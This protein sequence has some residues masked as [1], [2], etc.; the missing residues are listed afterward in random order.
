MDE[1]SEYNECVLLTNYLDDLKMEKKI[2][3]FTHVPNETFTKYWNV[4]VKNKMQ[5]V[6]PGFPDYII[7]FPNQMIIIEMK[8]RK[9][10]KVSDFQKE[11]IENLNKVGIPTFVC[12]G[13]DEAE[14]VIERY[15]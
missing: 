5:G 2:L 6:R 12:N 10:G 1:P 3:Q 14:K 13:F 15:L 9:G 7:L 8:I 11:W 4:K